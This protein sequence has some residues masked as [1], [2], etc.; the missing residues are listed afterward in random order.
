MSHCMLFLLSGVFFFSFLDVS[1]LSASMI[2]HSAVE[3]VW[4]LVN[5]HEEVRRVL[6]TI[7]ELGFSLREAYL[8]YSQAQCVCASLP[9][10]RS[11][12]L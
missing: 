4:I 1:V 2:P 12:Y 11:G 7:S 3:I 5:E 10:T 9:T 6:L 8:R